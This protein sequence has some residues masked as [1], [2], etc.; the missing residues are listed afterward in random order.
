MAL[1]TSHNTT[2]TTVVEGQW[3]NRKPLENQLQ[4][5]YHTCSPLSADTTGSSAS[6]GKWV[7]VLG[8]HFQWHMYAGTIRQNAENGICKMSRLTFAGN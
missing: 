5:F 3:K 7:V 4:P 8:I 6:I 2:I 1:D